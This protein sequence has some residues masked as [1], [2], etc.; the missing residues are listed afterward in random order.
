MNETD[1]PSLFQHNP[2]TEQGKIEDPF[3][4]LYRSA[5]RHF[6]YRVLSQSDSPW[7][8][9]M[10]KEWRWYNEVKND[11][12]I[13]KSIMRSWEEVRPPDQQISDF[14]DL[15]PTLMNVHQGTARTYDVRNGQSSPQDIA[16]HNL[17]MWVSKH[18]SWFWK[19]R[20]DGRAHA[21]FTVQAN[22]VRLEGILP[23][24]ILEVYASSSH[25]MTN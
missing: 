3:L 19:R 1:K 17:R 8:A 22:T 12:R 20:L 4:Q 2:E 23:G 10:R 18:L 5:R 7:E 21:L 16:A 25:D 24:P 13:W 14:I 15:D 6:C 9:T 11:E